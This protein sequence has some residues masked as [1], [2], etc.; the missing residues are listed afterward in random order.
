VKHVSPAALGTEIAKHRA[1]L[2]WTQQELADRIGISRTALSHIEAN[3]RVPGERTITLLAATFKIEPPEL[4]ADSDYPSSKSERLPLVAAR[5]TEVEHLL[6][7]LDGE[8]GALELHD[9]DP[10]AEWRDAWAA[11]L[12][13]RLRDTHDHRE[14]ALLKAAISGLA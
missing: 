13:S 7:R 3:M 11:T 1:Q 10:S 9:V 5:H 8:A 2:G 4:V 12:R 6:A 14:R